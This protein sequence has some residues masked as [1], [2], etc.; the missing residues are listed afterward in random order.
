MRPEQVVEQVAEPIP[1]G[2]TLRL[3]RIP[4][5][6]YILV[7]AGRARALAAIPIFRAQQLFW[8]RVAQQVLQGAVQAATRHPVMAAPVGA[9]SIM[10]QQTPAPSPAVLAGL[11]AA[12]MEPQVAAALLDRLVLAAQVVAQSFFHAAMAAAVTAAVLLA[13]LVAEPQ[14]VLVAITYSGRVVELVEPP[15][16]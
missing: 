6:L 7:L 15:A 1:S 13:L 11:R 9:R 10:P 3:R 4:Q 2:P 12:A 8:L 14:A 5:S 16:T